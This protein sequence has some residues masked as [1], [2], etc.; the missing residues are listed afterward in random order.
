MTVVNP[1]D[2]PKSVGNRCVIEAFVGVFRVVTLI[3]GFSRGCRGFCHRT[4]SDLFFFS[5]FL[6]ILEVGRSCDI[7]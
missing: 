1:T 4:E 5:W 7:K 3:F 2:R 6:V